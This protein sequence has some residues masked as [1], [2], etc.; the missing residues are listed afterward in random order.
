M[1]IG[2]K[3][4]IVIL[5][6]G[7]M[8][9]CGSSDGESGPSLNDARAPAPLDSA[10]D[11][12]VAASYINVMSVINGAVGELGEFN[13]LIARKVYTMSSKLRVEDNCDADSGRFV[14]DDT[15]AEETV[16]IEFYGCR[17]DGAVLDGILTLQ[18]LSGSFE[19]ESC[20]NERVFFGSNGGELSVVEAGE[21]FRITGDWEFSVNG[22]SE[23]VVQNL[24]ARV[25]RENELQVAYVADGLT[26]DVDY[27]SSSNPLISVNGKLGLSAAG[28]GI[29]CGLGGTVTL[30]AV[31]V[32]LDENGEPIGGRLRIDSAESPFALVEFQSNG[33]LSV[34]VNGGTSTITRAKYASLCAING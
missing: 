4:G 34:T 2:V 12:A 7:L 6:G 9:G 24:E 27:S 11:V 1:R 22:A 28:I 17:L 15:T 13:P 5:A 25:V 19:D 10:T 30:N 20:S 26:T 3:T 33:D 31:G 14:Y 29:D 32:A 21:V 16:R 23:T 18:C 8:V